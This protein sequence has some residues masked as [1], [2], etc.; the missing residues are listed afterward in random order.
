MLKKSFLTLH[1]HRTLP[2]CHRDVDLSGMGTLV[3][4]E[5]TTGHADSSILPVTYKLELLSIFPPIS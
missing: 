2:A 1:Q 4:G 3:S 5:P